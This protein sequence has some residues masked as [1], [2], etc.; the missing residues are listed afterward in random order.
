MKTDLTVAKKDES[1]SYKPYF[2]KTYLI[3]AKS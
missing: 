1:L 3:D 2:Q